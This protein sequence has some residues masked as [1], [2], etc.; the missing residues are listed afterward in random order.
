M[1]DVYLKASGHTWTEGQGSGSIKYAKDKDQE[2]FGALINMIEAL[3]KIE[4]LMAKEE[5]KK[6]KH[7]M[8][9]AKTKSSKI[10][11][12]I[13]MEQVLW[14]EECNCEAKSGAVIEAVNSPSK[15]KNKKGH[16]I[17]REDAVKGLGSTTQVTF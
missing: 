16:A 17:G 5:R 15:K 9:H 4:K 14:G 11:N 12:A 10:N 7:R 2:F 6:K 8:V 13:I 3:E 1:G